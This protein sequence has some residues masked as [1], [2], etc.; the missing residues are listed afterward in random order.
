MSKKATLDER[1]IVDDYVN[2]MVS[3][4][5]LAEKYHT[6]KKR[7]R[8]ILDEC[9]VKIRK[10]GK[11]KLDKS[12][13]KLT[14]FRI[15]KYKGVEGSHYVAVDRKSGYQ[16]KD[17]MNHGG[18]LTTYI[19]NEYGIKTPTLYDRRLYYM[20]TGNYWWE[21]WFD[22][23]LIDNEPNKKCPYCDW[24]TI[25][26]DNKSGAFEQHLLRE[27]NVTKFQYL[28]EHP[29]ELC[30]FEL[31]E[32]T[33]NLQMSENEDDF[34][35]CR[36]CGK[37]LRR[38]DDKH[39]HCHNITLDEYVE[40]YGVDDRVSKSLSDKM[41]AIGH[42]V[43]KNMTFHRVSTGES[44]IIEYIRSM[45]FKVSQNRKILDGLELDIFVE[46]K[47]IAF[48]YD[49][50]YWHNELYKSKNYHNDK[51]NACLSK[52]IKLIHIFEDEWLNKTDIVKSRINNMLG[53]TQQKI[54]ARKCE[55]KEVDS[56]TSNKF[57]D[58]NHLQGKVNSKFNYG[59]Y[60][61][62]SLVGLMT[63]GQLRKSLGQSSVD[64][65]FE[66]LRYCSK[67]NTNVIGGASK[68]L[69]HFIREE[70]PKTMI[71]YADRRWSDGK[72]YKTIGFE[73]DGISKPNYF[74]VVRNKRYHRFS[75]RK[76][77]LIKKYGCPEGMSEHEFCKS[78]QWFRIYDC[79]NMKFSLK[80]DM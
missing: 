43:N 45:G 74:Y 18:K 64:G 71:S 5:A 67:I 77:V 13:F 78:K 59:L 52:G 34:V 21:Q 48:E 35:V 36:L 75:F 70:N 38:I 37:K 25:D 42:E 55:V 40:Q 61:G 22:I 19:E 54:Y 66:M 57:L 20:R 47:N 23:R 73:L 6:S 53:V 24:E 63:F 79:G 41:S 62:G 60:Y 17:Y 3:V 31:V 9:N 14:D 4:D 46:D 50:L 7:I 69:K 33:A 56:E 58:E 26:V 51:T 16:T 30:Y 80:I 76:D 12:S 39:L 2:S 10:R 11:Q 68:L 32:P 27:H 15:E 65:S 72:L 8:A 49:G 29:E 44:E 28:K 1:T